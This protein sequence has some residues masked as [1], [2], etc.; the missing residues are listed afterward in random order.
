MRG[1]SN[2]SPGNGERPD[3]IRYS[4]PEYNGFSAVRRLR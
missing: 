1:S 2:N 3:I 4:T